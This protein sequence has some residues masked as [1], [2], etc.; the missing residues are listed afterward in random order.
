VNNFACEYLI[1]KDDSFVVLGSL[2]ALEVTDGVCG[3]NSDAVLRIR[4]VYPGS[5]FLPIPDHGSRIPDP[6][7][8]MKD[9]GEKKISCHTLFVATNFTKLYIIFFNAEE[10]NLGQFSKNYRTSYPQNCH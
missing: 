1:F 7:T 10:K 3:R 8:A 6:K 2:Q 4:D 9:R 5:C